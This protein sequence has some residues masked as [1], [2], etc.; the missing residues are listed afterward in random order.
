MTRLLT[1]RIEK[2]SDRVTPVG[3]Y[4]SLRDLHPQSIL[5]ESS[6]VDDRNHSHSILCAQPIAGI[7]LQDDRLRTFVGE[8]DEER[9]FDSSLRLDEELST[10]FASFDRDKKAYLPV[11]S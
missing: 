11:Q 2:F 10:F 8:K 5:L 9:A 7:S 6:E 3:M 4:L 1:H